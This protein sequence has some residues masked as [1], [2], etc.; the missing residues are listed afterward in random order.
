MN[1][2]NREE[3]KN[4]VMALQLVI[5]RDSFN[6]LC[7]IEMNRY[8]TSKKKREHL[9]CRHFFMHLEATQITKIVLKV[10]CARAARLF[11]LLEMERNGERKKGEKK[12]NGYEKWSAT[13][14]IVILTIERISMVCDSFQRVAST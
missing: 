1:V 2:R 11:H 8:F 14:V 4:I 13:I 6:C 7:G 10:V 9:M 5:L 3:R 12:K